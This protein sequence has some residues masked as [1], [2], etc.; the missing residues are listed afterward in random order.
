MLSASN[1]RKIS[2]VRP[3]MKD[4][5]SLAIL[6]RLESIDDQKMTG[7]TR[8]DLQIV[9]ALPKQ[10]R[11]MLMRVFN[12]MEGSIETEVEINCTAPGCGAPFKFDLDLGQVFFSTPELEVS[13]DNLDW[14]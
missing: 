2:E 12:K 14:V 1:E 5:K 13:L 10:D 9:K 6:A 11:L 7:D 4:V 8:Q 3:S